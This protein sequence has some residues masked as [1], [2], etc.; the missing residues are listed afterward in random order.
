LTFGKPLTSDWE[1]AGGLLHSGEYATATTTR[2]FSAHEHLDAH[3]LIH[4]NGRAYDPALGRFL[5]VDPL[6]QNPLNSQN[7]NGYSYV[8]NNPL[9]G[10]DPT[11]YECSPVDKDT[12]GCVDSNGNIISQP[13]TAPPGQNGQQGQGVDTADRGPAADQ[14][15]PGRP[16]QDCGGHGCASSQHSKGKSSWF[17]RTA[18]RVQRG[19]DRAVDWVGDRADAVLDRVQDGLDVASMALDG[20]AVGAAV[21]W[22][23]DLLNAGISGARGDWEGAALSA[24]AAVPVLGNAANATRL[25]RSLAK[26]ADNSHDAGKAAKGAKA[27]TLKPGPHAKGS[28]PARGPDRDFTRAERDAVNDLGKKHGCHT[29][30]TKDPGTKSGDFVPDHQPPNAVNPPRNPQKLYPHCLGCSRRQG[31]ELRTQQ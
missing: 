7:L 2:G 10:V 27:S 1:D 31:G 24:A 18:N 22:A 15:R 14:G 8:L 29:C 19:L 17:S 28:V 16:S 12:A 6:I 20:T 9:S 11:G 30:G 5:S 23:P 26:Q 3:G 25:S 21:S 13:Q 4:M